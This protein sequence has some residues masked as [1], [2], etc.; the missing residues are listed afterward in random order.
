MYDPPARSV[1]YCL[2]A[3]ISQRLMLSGAGAGPMPKMP[4][5]DWKITSR[6]P[7]TW[8]ATC[9]GAPMPRLTYQPSGI[10]RASRSAI[11]TRVSGLHGGN[12]LTFS[13]TS[14]FTA[15]SLRHRRLAIRHVQHA[16][17]VNS[18]RG[19]FFR[20]ERA[21][22]DDVLSLH[23]RQLGRRRHHRIEIARRRFVGQVSP[24]VGLPG[25]NQRYVAG[26][27]FFQQIFAAANLPL[28]LAFGELGADG[29]RRIE[30]RNA[31]A[32]GAHAFR[33]GPLRY[34]FK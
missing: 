4:F 24:A 9:S 7:G 32:G 21:E 2:P 20:I 1:T 14:T 10:S 26:K 30:G 25:L 17:D 23:D 22:F 5:S 31:S 19:D 15:S 3:L 34:D 8:S 28:F 33:H 27:R 29:G 16:V 12:V 13:F 18:R 6:S 11:C